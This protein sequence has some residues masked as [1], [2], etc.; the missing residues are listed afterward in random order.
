MNIRHVCI[1]GGEPTMQPPD[2]L[3]TLALNLLNVDH[4]IDVFTN[5]SL[6]QLPDWMQSTLVRVILDWKL[7]GS[8]EST[9]GLDVR[10]KNLERL[11][12]TDMI[13]FVIAN[14]P[15]FQAAYGTWLETR[16]YTVAQYS[17]GVAWNKVKE[18]D[19]VDWMLATQVPWRLNVQ[20]H[21]YIYPGRDRLI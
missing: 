8:G 1:T 13:K 2:E 9:R 16:M 11:K 14:E 5:G 3:Y 20:V 17:A 10:T 7:P 21:K 6:T 12:P 19:L 18:E 15:D 4:T